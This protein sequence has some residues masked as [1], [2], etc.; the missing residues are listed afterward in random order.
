MAG[1]TGL[2]FPGSADRSELSGMLG[3][4][5]R[6]TRA[7]H[8]V[9]RETSAQT[10]DPEVGAEA[11][12]LPTAR[13][14][15][16]PKRSLDDVDT[17][18]TQ[19]DAGE[20][21]QVN[22]P[23]DP[24]VVT[25]SRPPQP[26]SANVSRET[27]LDAALPRPA[28]PRTIVIAN[29]KGGVGKTST[30]VNLAVAL[31][32][33]GLKVLL[34]DLDPQGNASTALNI[35]HQMGVAGSYEVLLQGS[36]IAEHVVASPEA[37]GLMVLPATIDLAGAELELVSLIARE[38]QLVKALRSYLR[39]HETDYVLLDCPPSL[40]L[41]TVNA[42]VAADEILI[43][44]QCEYYALEGV[45]QLMH[46]IN[47]VKGDLNERLQLGAVLLTMFDARTKLSAQVAQ[48]VRAHFSTQTLE[49]IIPRSVRVSEAPSY[50][51][52]VMTYDPL[53]VGSKA[54]R[55]AAAEIAR[56]GAAS[57]EN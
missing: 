22:A 14:R 24:A 51:Q 44:I 12:A 41:L 38:R 5:R 45:T 40:G 10:T 2:G 25:A 43:P 34:C 29:Q 23:M 30:A 35:P 52:T 33:G 9:S 39:D 4:P 18:K 1:A 7:A 16:A 19:Q 17:T 28:R 31:A 11:P 57:E 37:D 53:S 55:R 36:P 6:A 13:P 42:L 49:A 32:Q 46:T 54:Y 20:S 56:R 47:L 27:M 48:E 26:E 15:R 50:G 3:Y 21:K 8:D